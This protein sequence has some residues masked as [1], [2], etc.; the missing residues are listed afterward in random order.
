MPTF[1]IEVIILVNS[2]KKTALI[3]KGVHLM[4]LFA[5]GTGLLRSRFGV[6]AVAAVA[7]GGI[8]A[9]CGGSS[10]TSSSSTSA[11]NAAAISSGGSSTQLAL[12]GYSTPKK[13]YDAL[14]TAF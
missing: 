5:S 10:D 14:T 8:L 6:A 2:I 1:S 7:A 4:R 3:G 11:S 12:V 9:G 13:A